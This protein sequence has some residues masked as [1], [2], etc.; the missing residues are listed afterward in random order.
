MVTVAEL[1]ENSRQG[2]EVQKPTCVRLEGDLSRKLRWG[3]GYIY[4]KTPVDIA[5]YVRNDPVNRIDP[6]GRQDITLWHDEQAFWNYMFYYGLAYI[7]DIFIDQQITVSSA[8]FVFGGGTD[9]DA[10][11]GGGGGGGGE[12]NAPFVHVTNVSQTGEGYQ[13]IMRTLDYIK[14]N[15]TD[16][17]KNA[18]A[19]VFGV[20]DQITKAGAVA[21][22]QFDTSINAFVSGS[23]TD[24]PAGIVIAVNDLGLFFNASLIYTAGGHVGGTP[25]AQVF[26]LL[27]EL[28]HL[29]HAFGATDNDAGPGNE[30]NGRANDAIINRECG[31]MVNGPILIP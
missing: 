1:S 30:A 24:L 4:D 10:N 20:I 21:T 29:T 17:C 27:H 23:N 5:V 28:G 11:Y 12:S 22:A 6:D 13:M 3:C 26:I 9:S 16:Q 15:I 7:S 31:G 14:N 19:G 8:G 18:L 25:N 2:F